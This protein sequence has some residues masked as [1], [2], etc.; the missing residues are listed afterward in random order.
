MCFFLYNSKCNIEV[1][2]KVGH[3]GYFDTK[4]MSVSLMVLEIG[5]I[6][7]FTDSGEQYICNIDC[8]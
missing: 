8:C 2:Y 6:G 7:T 4:Y 5:H 1:E 3:C